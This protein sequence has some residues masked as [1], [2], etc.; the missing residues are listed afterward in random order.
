M[1]VNIIHTCIYLLS[2][3][4]PS[5]STTI[6]IHWPPIRSDPTGSK[7]PHLVCFKRIIFQWQ[8]HIHISVNKQWSSPSYIFAASVGHKAWIIHWE[9]F[10]Y[11]CKLQYCFVLFVFKMVYKCGIHNGGHMW[12]SQLCCHDFSLRLK[13]FLTLCFALNPRWFSLLLPIICLIWNMPLETSCSTPNFILSI[14][15]LAM[16]Y[17]F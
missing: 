3:P 11:F 12:H 7:L 6:T 4:P 14:L 13:I 5:P 1:I 16:I 15:L 17:N 9:G 10:C 2:T 8:V